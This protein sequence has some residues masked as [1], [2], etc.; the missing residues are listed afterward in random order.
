[1]LKKIIIKYMRR[2]KIL[3]SAKF[4]RV[5]HKDM[6]LQ[7]VRNSHCMHRI[8][9]DRYVNSMIEKVISCYPHGWKIP[10]ST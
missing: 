1:M 8:D 4:K 7:S 3:V 10:H 2:E 9:L 6:G 5:I